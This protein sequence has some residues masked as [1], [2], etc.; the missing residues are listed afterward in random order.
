MEERPP[1]LTIAVLWLALVVGMILHFNFDMS[2]LRYGVSV[3]LP[4]ATGLVPWSNFAI[5]VLFYVVPFLLAVLATTSPGPGYRAFHF[6]V[7]VIFGLANASHVV[8]T[9]LRAS[10]VLG[11]AQVILL[12]AVLMANLQLSRVAHRWWRPGRVSEP[13]PDLSRSQS[14]A[15]SETIQT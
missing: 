6:I 13:A 9:S 15:P 5:K 8:V 7:T 10:E 4:D 3:E 2:G 11:Y 14:P 12:V 1:A